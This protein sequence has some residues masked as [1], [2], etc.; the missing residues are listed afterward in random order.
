M[1]EQ[2]KVIIQTHE[3]LPKVEELAQAGYRLVQIGCSKAKNFELTYSFDKDYSLVNLRLVLEEMQ[4]IPS[5]TAHYG[6][7]FIYENEIH[8][9]FGLPIE[10]MNVDFKGRMYRMAVK[11]PFNTGKV[12]G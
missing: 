1:N 2:K 12:T 9:L 8:D 7:A 6:Y 10:Q 3:L 4:A 5:I 11:T